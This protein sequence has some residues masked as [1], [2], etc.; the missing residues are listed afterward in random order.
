MREGIYH[1]V[2]FDLLVGICRRTYSI[3]IAMS[4]RIARLYK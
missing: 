4:T 2:L 1:D 3:D